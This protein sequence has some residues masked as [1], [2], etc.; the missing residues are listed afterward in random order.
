MVIEASILEQPSA[1]KHFP[2]YFPLPAG[3][4]LGRTHSQRRT[5]YR[6]HGV[7]ATQR[8]GELQLE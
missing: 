2:L 4:A 7:A 3:S 1:E 5:H 8:P 6:Q